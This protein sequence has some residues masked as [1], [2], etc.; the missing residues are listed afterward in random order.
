MSTLTVER[1]PDLTALLARDPSQK[2]YAAEL[3]S[4]FHSLHE[5]M[6]GRH[7]VKL[8]FSIDDSDTF[9][10]KEV[11]QH[12]KPFYPVP[13]ALA[14]EFTKAGFPLPRDRMVSMDSN[15]YGTSWKISALLPHDR[16]QAY[17]GGKIAAVSPTSIS[18]EPDER[19]ATRNLSGLTVIITGGPGKGLT[20]TIASYDAATNTATMDADWQ[21][22]P[23]AGSRF[24]I[25]S[26]APVEGTLSQVVQKDGAWT[27]TLNPADEALVDAGELPG[28]RLQIVAGAGTGLLGTIKS[29]DAA[30]KTV[31]MEAD[32]QPLPTAESTFIVT[33]L[34]TYTL[35]QSQRRLDVYGDSEDP[36]LLIQYRIAQIDD[37]I[38][39]QLSLIMH[40]PQF[41]QLEASWRGLHDLVHKTET[42]TRMKL[43]VMN[44]TRDELQNDLDNAVEFDQSALFKKIYE[45]EYGLF[46]GSPYSALMADFEF[47]RLPRDVSM[48]QKL[49]NVAA[50]AHAPLITAA[51]PGLFDLQSFRDLDKPRDLAKIF[52]SAELI[53]WRSFRESEDSRYVAL[54]LP[55]TM[56]RLPY[57]PSTIP[58]NEFHFVED[59]SRPEFFLWGNAAWSLA[60]R[61]TEAFARYGWTA[62]IRGYEGGGMVGGLPIYTFKSD[63]G[64]IAVQIPTEVAIT[65]RREKELSDLGFI[66][67]C[68]RKGTDSATFFGGQTAN[69]PKVYV[70]DDATANARLSAQLPYI[71]ATS[72]FAHYIKVIMRDKIG[73]FLTQGNVAELLN[74][75]IAQYVMLNDDAGQELK[76]RYPLREARVDVTADPARPGCYRA[77]VFLRPH[78]QLEELTVSLR[79]VA[80]L[81]PPAA[82]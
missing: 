60:Q 17:T 54:A 28:K 9:S 19:L 39:R 65:D 11:V 8:L 68:Y 49:S 35:K 14:Q 81:P 7:A 27:L 56:M 43:R 30:T 59:A 2:E 1:R 55:H 41:Q 42:G 67:L 3:I 12:L 50:A 82:G 16:E 80:T 4:E 61:M 47:G 48:L 23:D 72:R 31:T 52:E 69:K 75:W 76:S 70:Q 57:G 71:L 58:V 51:A 6:H 29:Y 64:D 46:G 5:K 53:K 15:R 73:S 78:F 79:L 44:A 21:P 25:N 32:W 77:V 66:A 13:E 63:D 34:A 24:A 10:V 33:R 18:F 22:M 40:H 36:A 38:S 37:L 20:G 26:G 74:N 62:A 45:E